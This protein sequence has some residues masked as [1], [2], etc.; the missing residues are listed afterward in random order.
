MAHSN[1]VPD[2][3]KNTEHLIPQEIWDVIV[4]EAALNAKVAEEDGR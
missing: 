1:T 2:D 3:Q 4:A